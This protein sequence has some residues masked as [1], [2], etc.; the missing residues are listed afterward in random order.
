[1]NYCVHYNRRSLTSIVSPAD[2]IAFSS[3]IDIPFANV[4]ISPIHTSGFVY[5]IQKTCSIYMCDVFL[6][7]LLIEKPLAYT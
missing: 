2:Y 3:C 5:V 1:M 7:Q 4:S 6:T